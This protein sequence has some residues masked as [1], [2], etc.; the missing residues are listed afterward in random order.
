MKYKKVISCHF[1]GKRR[2]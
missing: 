2:S 1:K